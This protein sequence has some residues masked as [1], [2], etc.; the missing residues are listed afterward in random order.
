[1]LVVSYLR[2]EDLLLFSSKSFIVLA[3]PPQVSPSGNEATVQ[4]I[5]NSQLLRNPAVSPPQPHIL[6]LTYLHLPPPH[7]SSASSLPK[8]TT[9][10][11][12]LHPWPCLGTV[13]T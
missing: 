5:H 13:T 12:L 11:S 9:I 3:F 1:M 2:N 10:S 4:P 6:P 8:D 7:Y